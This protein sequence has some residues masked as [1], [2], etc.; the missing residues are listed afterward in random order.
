LIPTAARRA[1]A[2]LPGGIRKPFDIGDDF[3][4]TLGAK[5]DRHTRT[6]IFTPF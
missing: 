6:L 1:V 5:L 3:S 2:F 4:Q